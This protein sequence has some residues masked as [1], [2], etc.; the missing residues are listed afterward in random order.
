MLPSIRIGSVSILTY[1]LMIGIGALGML[2]CT[3]KRRDRFQLNRVQCVLFTL[4]LTLCGIAG[5]RLLFIL[6]NL[7]NWKKAIAGNGVSF[8]GSVYLIPLVMPLIGCIFQL[9]APC[10]HDLCGPCVAVMVGFI[11]MGCFMND[12]CGGWVMYVGDFY[13]TWPTQ[14]IE[15]IGDFTIF[16]WLLQV[17]K[18]GSRQGQLYPLFMISYSTLR[19]FVEFLRYSPNKWF[20]F[21]AGH[22]FA[23]VAIVTA[24]LWIAHDRK[25]KWVP[26]SINSCSR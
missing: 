14:I 13:F 10:T 1:P 7:D 16:A 18:R 9:K 8:F 15:C 25:N 11:R 19:F 24:L 5:A 12:C 17:E 20:C 4:L 21:S 6:E 2:V 22:G 23:F 3:W 26:G